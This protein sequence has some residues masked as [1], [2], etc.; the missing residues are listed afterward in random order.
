M[1][2]RYLSLLL[3]CYF[4][5]ACSPSIERIQTILKAYISASGEDGSTIL[6]NVEQ[7]DKGI[8]TG[9]Y[10]VQK[11]SLTLF[12][13]P[14]T[15][16]VKKDQVI[17]F[18]KDTDDK[19]VSVLTFLTEG[20]GQYHSDETG[21][22]YNVETKA[23]YE[24]R[25]R[26]EEEERQ[27][28]LAASRRAS[29]SDLGAKGANYLMSH[30]NNIVQIISYHRASVMD[31]AKVMFGR[32]AVTYVYK[33]LEANGIGTNTAAYDVIFVNGN[34]VSTMESTTASLESIHQQASE[35]IML[36]QILGQ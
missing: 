23:A 33:V 9:T 20:Q 21:L 36:K 11:D 31:V 13:Y 22:D 27:A 6:M 8:Y 3:A 5:A 16:I 29:G 4:A 10:G 1:K 35:A 34:I 18:F 28:A 32:N 12:V 24:E 26:K 19:K 30:N 2:L 25:L 15:A 17:Q 14:F 7:T